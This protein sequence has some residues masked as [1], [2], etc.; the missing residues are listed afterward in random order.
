MRNA[1][2]DKEGIKDESLRTEH[3]HLGR[4]GSGERVREVLREVRAESGQARA[5]QEKRELNCQ[6]PR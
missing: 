5:D 3:T 4:K 1:E 2:R 6:S